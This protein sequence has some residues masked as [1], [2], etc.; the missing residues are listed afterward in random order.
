MVDHLV[1]LQKFIGT[2]LNKLEIKET[3][4]KKLFKELE[5]KEKE[6]DLVRN[7]DFGFGSMAGMD[8]KELLG[9]LNGYMAR[10]AA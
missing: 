1:S 3:R 10:K 8:G 6:I 2:R 7:F 5:S 9:F 4:V